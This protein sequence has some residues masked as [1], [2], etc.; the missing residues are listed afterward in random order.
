MRAALYEFNK[1]VE[2]VLD[3]KTF[4]ETRDF[5]TKYVNI[6]T[7]TKDAELGYALDSKFYGIPNY[8]RYIKDN[9]SKLTLTDVNNAIKKHFGSADAMR[10]V[11]ITKDA[12]NLRNAIVGNAPSSDFLQHAETGGDYR[13]RQKDS[14]ITHR[15]SPAGRNYHT[16]RTRV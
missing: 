7:Q 2:N 16:N 12:E 11:M 10:I 14:I 15:R 3:Q 5:L 1:L 13:R 9:L 6:S 8:N 4:E